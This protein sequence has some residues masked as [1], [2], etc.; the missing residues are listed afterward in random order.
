MSF[1]KNRFKVR[2]C[3]TSLKG[4]HV[5]VVYSVLCTC[6]ILIMFQFLFILVDY[7]QI[8]FAS[9]PFLKEINF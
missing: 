2:A 8:S 5:H 1:Y 7:L 6:N 4:L 3:E 9:T